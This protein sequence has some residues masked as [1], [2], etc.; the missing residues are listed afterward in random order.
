LTKQEFI[1]VS[2]HTSIGHAILKE[3][4]FPPEVALAALQHHER[5]SGGGYPIGIK[6]V[7]EIG[8]IVGMIDVYEALTN[9]FRPY[10]KPTAPINALYV[11]KQDVDKGNI[12]RDL[13]E[14]FAYSLL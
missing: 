1:E 2:K 5:V 10:R 13:F 11:I 3:A 4:D 9:P 7:S 12:R 8:Q 6:N 14:E